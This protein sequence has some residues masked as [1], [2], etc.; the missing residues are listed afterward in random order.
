MKRAELAIPTAKE[1]YLRWLENEL[2]SESPRPDRSYFELVWVMFEKE[3]QWSPELPWSV[4]MDDNRLAEGMELRTEFADLHGYSREE[5]AHLGPCSFLEV[6]IGLARR[7]SFVA[8]GS[9][10]RWA[11]QLVVNLGLD[12]MWD[13]LSRPKTR[14]VL[15]VMDTVIKRNYHPNGVGGFFP[16][17]WTDRDQR[18]VELWYQLNAY[19]EELHPGN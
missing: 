12:R 17:S 4:A 18:Q 7:M 11:W 13:H 5:M 9:S 8:G 16:L 19:V 14:K 2:T 10:S 6:L 15:Q 1:H 3:F